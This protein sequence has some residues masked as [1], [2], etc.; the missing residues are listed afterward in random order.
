M[1]RKF[2]H[3]NSS[4]LSPPALMST[5]EQSYLDELFK[6]QEQVANSEGSLYE[7]FKAAWPY[8]EGNMPYVDSWHIR[9]IAEH[10]EAVYARQIRKLII[11]VPPR[12]GKPVGQYTLLLKKNGSRVFIKDIEI[13][14]Y[15]QTHK[16]RFRK[17]L[18]KYCQGI[19]IGY[20][21]TTFSGRTIFGSVASVEKE[22]R[23]WYKGIKIN[24]N[25]ISYFL[26]I[27][28]TF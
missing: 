18:A 11:N 10:L 22:F 3:I 5:F 26:Q 13:G 21:I 24:P 17:V 6:V 14:D 4:L 8:I 7:F 12:T 9:A 28:Q 25:A 27:T 23:I 16:G 2:D 1:K 19:Q 15:I 20:T